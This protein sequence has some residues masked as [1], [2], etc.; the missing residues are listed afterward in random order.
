MDGATNEMPKNR[1]SLDSEEIMSQLRKLNAVDED[2]LEVIQEDAMRNRL[3]ER[4]R[5]LRQMTKKVLA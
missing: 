3:Y 1:F 5:Q 4:R 2:P